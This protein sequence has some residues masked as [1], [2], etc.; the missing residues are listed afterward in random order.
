MATIPFGKCRPGYV[1][2][3]AGGEFLGEIKAE[4][5]K[6]VTAKPPPVFVDYVD[7]SGDE[8]AAKYGRPLWH[9]A[10]RRM[11]PPKRIVPVGDPL[12][13]MEVSRETADHHMA[14]MQASLR[15]ERPCKLQQ[16]EKQQMK[17][18]ENAFYDKDLEPMRVQALILRE[19]HKHAINKYSRDRTTQDGSMVVDRSVFLQ[20][21]TELASKGGLTHTN[22]WNIA[23]IYSETRHTTAIDKHGR[24]T[25]VDTDEPKIRVPSACVVD[26]IHD[27]SEF[28]IGDI[29]TGATP[30][31]TKPP[32]TK[33]AASYKRTTTKAAEIGKLGNPHVWGG[34]SYVAGQLINDMDGTHLRAELKRFKNRALA[35][36]DED[37]E[38][39]DWG[40]DDEVA[41]D[42]E[43][44]LHPAYGVLLVRAHNLGLHEL[45]RKYKPSNKDHG[46]V[47]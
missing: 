26:L 41:K 43:D 4:N 17:E 25:L 8:L 47:E 2:I 24:P 21:L 34:G 44:F 28:V 36:W 27:Y 18:K 40:E 19:R 37:D 38:D 12:G 11:G 5:W 22:G 31:M 6:P 10:L 32:K 45:V 9:N 3:H 1:G 14:E 46:T 29:V 35:L 23:T 7:E 42:W 20:L 39:D 33:A 13:V 16:Q 15:G 30:A